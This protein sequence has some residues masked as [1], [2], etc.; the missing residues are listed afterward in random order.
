MA[1]KCASN[2][3]TSPDEPRAALLHNA[4]EKWAEA[5][6]LIQS[7][8]NLCHACLSLLTYCVICDSEAE[9]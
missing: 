7:S 3:C 6:A 8:Y 4:V 9:G 1:G 2:M 5:L